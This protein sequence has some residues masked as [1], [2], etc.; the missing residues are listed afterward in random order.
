MNCVIQLNLII[1]LCHTWL[2]GKIL[3]GALGG[4]EGLFS[5]SLAFTVD[6]KYFRNARIPKYL[7]LIELKCFSFVSG[8][9][10]AHES[11]DHITNELTR[12]WSWQLV[13]LSYVVSVLGCYTTT[14]ILMQASECKTFARK[15][16]WT[17]L[18][19][20]T[21]GGVS[22]GRSLR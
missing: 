19:S 20:L 13:L 11:D 2:L 6:Q 7:W 17:F 8:V 3:A 14:Q 18:A 16:S 22:I 4:A 9:R 21:L 5:T 15:L 10:M 12:H 1:K